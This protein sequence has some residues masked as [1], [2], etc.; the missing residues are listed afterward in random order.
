MGLEKIYKAKEDIEKLREQKREKTFEHRNLITILKRLDIQEKAGNG[1][2]RSKTFNENL[3]P[4]EDELR[5]IAEEI[6]SIRTENDLKPGK[7]EILNE[8]L[9]RLDHIGISIPTIYTNGH[10]FDR[11]NR[12]KDEI[13]KE[14]DDIEYQRMEDEM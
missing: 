4:I 5:K 2:T 6:I 13:K 14:I 11:I 8:R 10:V 1:H 3:S 9:K 7:I 12:L